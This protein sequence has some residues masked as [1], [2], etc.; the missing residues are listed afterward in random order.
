MCEIQGEYPQKANIKIWQEFGD[1]NTCTNHSWEQLISNLSAILKDHLWNEIV[2]ND[3]R[4][5]RFPKP[6]LTPFLLENCKGLKNVAQSYFLKSWVQCCST[7][8]CSTL[9][10][11][12]IQLPD[13]S[14][15]MCL[16]CH[17]HVLLSLHSFSPLQKILGNTTICVRPESSACGGKSGDMGR[18]LLLGHG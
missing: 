18:L 2:F 8:A 6:W 10:T 17:S 15:V 7:H 11:A 16:T 12:F 5:R 1:T 3:L 4:F 9:N 14:T 13:A